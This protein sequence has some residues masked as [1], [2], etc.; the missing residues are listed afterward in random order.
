MACWVQDSGNFQWKIHEVK[1]RSNIRSFET[2]DHF[3]SHFQN[4]K[5]LRLVFDVE[6]SSRKERC[7]IWRLRFHIKGN[8]VLVPDSI[9][10]ARG[11]LLGRKYFNQIDARLNSILERGGLF[12]NSWPNRL[13]G[14]LVDWAFPTIDW[15]RGGGT[16]I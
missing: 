4:S 10:E 3:S 11:Y 13:S 14:H 7:V 1:G 15:Y 8:S 5:A 9:P 6:R 12:S 2:F 16:V